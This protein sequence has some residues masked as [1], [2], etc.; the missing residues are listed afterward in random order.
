MKMALYFL[1]TLP[2]THDRQ[3]EDQ[4]NRVGKPMEQNNEHRQRE[5]IQSSQFLRYLAFVERQTLMGQSASPLISIS[6]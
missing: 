4:R 5:D 2:A 3:S 1:R 6:Y